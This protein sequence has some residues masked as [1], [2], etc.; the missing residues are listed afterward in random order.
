MKLQYLII[1]RGIGMMLQAL[2]SLA[3]AFSLVVLIWAII[4]KLTGVF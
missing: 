4:F 2:L 1:L 3:F